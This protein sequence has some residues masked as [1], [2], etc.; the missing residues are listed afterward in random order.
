MRKGSRRG[1]S[2]AFHL[3]SGEMIVLL[4]ERGF[5]AAAPPDFL[6]ADRSV[7][8][9]LVDVDSAVLREI[10]VLVGQ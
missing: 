1:A 2:Y 10:E 7:R 5:V 9:P 8:A 3:L 6:D 4:H